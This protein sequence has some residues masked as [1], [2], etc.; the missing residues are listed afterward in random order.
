MGPYWARSEDRKGQTEAP[1]ASHTDV[2]AI[3]AGAH[4]ALALTKDGEVV[5]WGDN[6]KQQTDI[7]AEVKAATA[8]AIAAGKDTSVAVVGGKVYA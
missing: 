5:A 6:G 1:E 7:P 2:T 8:T 4:H 3:A